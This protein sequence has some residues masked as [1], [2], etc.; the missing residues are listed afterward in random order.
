MTDFTMYNW[1]SEPA[2]TFVSTPT[3]ASIPY[4]S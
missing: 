2:P 3:N 4:S 1:P